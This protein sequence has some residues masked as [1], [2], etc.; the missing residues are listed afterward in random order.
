MQLVQHQSV[1]V[2]SALRGLGAT[3]KDVIHHLAAR[4]ASLVLFRWLVHL[5]SLAADNFA[6]LE[7][8]LEM[9]SIPHNHAHFVQRAHLATSKVR[10]VKI[11][12]NFAM[13]ASIQLQALASA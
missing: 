11:A 13:P 1:I 2:C 6:Q 8:G 9:A 7:L 5:T 10:L 3:K 12:A 4:S